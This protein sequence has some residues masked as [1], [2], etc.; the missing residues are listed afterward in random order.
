MAKA[1]FVFRPW[2]TT[3]DGKVIYAKDYGLKA[4]KIRVLQLNNRYVI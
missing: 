3:R 2:I 4:F 1:V